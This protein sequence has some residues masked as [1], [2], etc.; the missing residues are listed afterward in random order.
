MKNKK[1][2]KLKYNEVEVYEREHAQILD[3]LL[4]RFLGEGRYKAMKNKKVTMWK[5][6]F[7]ATKKELKIMETLFTKAICP[8][9]DEFYETLLKEVES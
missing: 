5:F 7:W 8:D 4:C 2:K 6:K 1:A 3:L 9:W